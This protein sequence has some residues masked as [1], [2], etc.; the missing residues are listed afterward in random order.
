MCKKAKE[1]KDATKKAELVEKTKEADEKHQRV[2]QVALAAT[3]AVQKAADLFA[4]CST[5]GG[6]SGADMAS[7]CFNMLGTLLSKLKVRFSI[8]AVIITT[9]IYY[10]GSHPFRLPIQAQDRIGA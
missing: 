1:K 8:I 2:S 9:T 7:A 10:A 6:C 3:E 4:K 5:E